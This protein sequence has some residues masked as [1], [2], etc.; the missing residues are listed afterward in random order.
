MHGRTLRLRNFIQQPGLAVAAECDL[1]FG[2]PRDSDP[3]AN[4]Y[5]GV[6]GLAAP[7]HFARWEDARAK[8]PTEVNEIA[9]VREYQ[10]FGYRTGDPT[11][12]KGV[13]ALDVMK[14]WRSEGLFGRHIAAFAHVD[15][16]DTQQ[17]QTAVFLLGGVFLC[18]SLPKKV[19]AGSIYEADVWDV[20]KDDGGREGG[21]MVWLYGDLCNTWGKQVLITPAFRA[22]YAFEAYAVVSQWSLHDGRSFAG[23]DLDGLLRAVAQI[24]A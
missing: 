19:A 9:V 2:L 15:H 14:H 8:R 10:R 18:L 16:Y 22:R 4:D 7:G 17:V 1:T 13:Y 21:H 20:A 5:L 24:T 11:T 6:C 12:D 23:L 3:L